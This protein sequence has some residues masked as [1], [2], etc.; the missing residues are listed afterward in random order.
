LLTRNTGLALLSL[1]RVV[2]PLVA[3]ALT[4]PVGTVAAQRS[5]VGS[6]TTV[7][8][9]GHA[10]AV[11]EIRERNG[12]LFG[13]VRALLVPAT[14]DDSLCGRCSGARRNEPI[15]GLEI[16]SHMRPHGSEWTGGEILDPE[17]GRTYHATM[18]L[19]DDGRRLI[20]RG[21]IGTSF[22][23][24]SETWFRKGSV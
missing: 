22:F 15:V 8:D 19:T 13:V 9:D 21:Y 1:R 10:T 7:G 2:Q 18:R 16:L 24:R 20:V 6:W 12:E 5:P 23:G 4:V 14:H 11:V 3:L 17:N